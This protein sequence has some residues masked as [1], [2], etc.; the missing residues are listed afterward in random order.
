M[1]LTQSSTPPPPQPPQIPLPDAR[2]SR[3]TVALF[4]LLLVA[5]GLGIGYGGAVFLRP[6]P[7]LPVQIVVPKN[8]PQNGSSAT[9]PPELELRY[10][11]LKNQLD[12]AA[13]NSRQLDRL[14]TLLLTLTTLYALALGLNSYF[15]L[16]Q[17]LDSGKEDLGRLREFLGQS[18]TEVKEKLADV[19]TALEAFQKEIRERYPE[20]ANLHAN[21]R[22]VFD[23]IRLMFQPGQNWTR[24]FKDMTPEQRERFAVAEMRLAGLEVFRL[25]D[26]DSF[27]PDVLRLYQALGRFYSSRFLEK[28]LRADWERAAIYFRAAVQLDPAK[29]PADL[30]KDVGVHLSMIEQ[31]VDKRRESG[32][33]I[34]PV[35]TREVETLRARAEAAF[36][37][38][39][40]ANPNEP[41]ALVGF[42]WV[43]YKQGN[44]R[45]ALAQ[46]ILLTGIQAWTSS[47]REKFLEGGWLNRAYCHSLLAGPDPTDTAYA[48]AL[49]EL[50][51]S[52]KVAEEYGRL[53]QWKTTVE[54]ESASGDLRKLRTAKPQ[55]LVQVLA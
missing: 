3:A 49:S 22:G 9:V 16:R 15:G 41:G 29:P 12:N 26:L 25:G 6:A 5:A 11:L 30:M 53:P 34:P 21:L 31:L 52:R 2:V 33:P 39:L 51:E 10:Q 43:L 50:K 44:Y 27:R 48:S 13:E 14:L 54:K 45:D 18:R 23:E 55:E 36:R 46:S 40:G 35:E 7:V 28:K 4:A 20:L 38:S 19:D 17:I 42:S 32:E 1:G 24:Q 37:E 47:D 8:V